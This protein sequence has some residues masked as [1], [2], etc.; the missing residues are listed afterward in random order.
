MKHRYIARG[1]SIATPGP[2]LDG[3]GGAPAL[4]AP[5][6]AL[7]CVVAVEPSLEE[8]EQSAID[9]KNRVSLLFTRRMRLRGELVDTQKTHAEPSAKLAESQKAHAELSAKLADMQSKH[10]ASSEQVKQQEKAYNLTE[11][12][13]P[14]AQEA[15]TEAESRFRTN[16]RKRPDD[17]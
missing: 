8:L 6:A 1:I 15:E 12:L 16:K 2:A 14:G 3:A 4:P 11:N 5:L 13:L 17:E 7:G 10:A 9:T